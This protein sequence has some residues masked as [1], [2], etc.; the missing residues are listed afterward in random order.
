MQPILVYTAYRLPKQD[1]NP[2]LSNSKASIDNQCLWFQKKNICV[3]LETKTIYE[4]N[5]IEKF[6]TA[7]P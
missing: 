6:L 7:M 5:F 4:K 2:S 3:E 1:S